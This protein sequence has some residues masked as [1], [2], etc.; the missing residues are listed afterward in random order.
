MILANYIFIPRAM[1]TMYIEL[2]LTIYKYLNQEVVRN[3][4][5]TMKVTNKS[6]WVSP[7]QNMISARSYSNLLANRL[8]V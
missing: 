7:T 4:K 6:E 8:I 3:S 1:R 2:Y 5:K